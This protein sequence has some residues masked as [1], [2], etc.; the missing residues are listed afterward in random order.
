MCD[1]SLV[2]L[3]KIPPHYSQCSRENA[4]D[5]IQWHNPIILL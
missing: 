4:R 1:P 2:D 5:T 3:L